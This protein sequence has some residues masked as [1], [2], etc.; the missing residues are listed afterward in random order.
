M[1]PKQVLKS[2][3]L[4]HCLNCRRGLRNSGS[5]WPI[6][7]RVVSGGFEQRL[8]FFGFARERLEPMESPQVLFAC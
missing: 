5:W 3:E 2:V 7:N 4:D 6:D 8:Q 1:T